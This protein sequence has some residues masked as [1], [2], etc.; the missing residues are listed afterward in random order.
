MW[1]FFI[2]LLAGASGFRIFS[3]HEYEECEEV[4]R[5]KE[6]NLMFPEILMVPHVTLDNLDG[7]FVLLFV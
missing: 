3:S 7:L 5:R 2:S 4:E 1:W 6:K